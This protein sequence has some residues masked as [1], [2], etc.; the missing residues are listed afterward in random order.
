MVNYLSR[1]V[2]QLSTLPA[3]LTELADST[4]IWEWQNIHTSAVNRIKQVLVANM[5]VRPIDYHLVE[6]IFLITNASAV[7]I[8]AR[9]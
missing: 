8:G 4:T 2:L 7:G 5:V 1:F 6:P 9:V 3:P